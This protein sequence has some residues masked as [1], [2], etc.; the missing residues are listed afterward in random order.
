MDDEAEGV[1]KEA[2]NDTDYESDEEA[3]IHVS[4]SG[5]LQDDLRL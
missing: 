2:N 5:T 3:L 1:G 4:V